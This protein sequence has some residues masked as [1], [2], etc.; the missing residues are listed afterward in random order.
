MISRHLLSPQQYLFLT[1][2]EKGL[3]ENWNKSENLSRISDLAGKIIETLEILFVS[4]NLT[5]KYLNNIFP[6]WRL[7]EVLGNMVTFNSEIPLEQESNKLEIARYLVTIGI[8]YYEQR[9]QD[10]K[11]YAKKITETKDLLEDL[12]RIA[13][14]QIEKSK[15][16]R[17]P[18]YITKSKTLAYGLC[19]SCHAYAGGF[20]KKQVIQKLRH[21][22]ECPYDKKDP[23]KFIHIIPKLK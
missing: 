13:D 23:D 12:N 9:F 16:Y 14:T 3:P 20:D 11:L 8:S 15:I 7:N 6:A 17:V 2:Q 5:Q 21:K 18:P 10:S 19:M 1:S 4:K 22:Q